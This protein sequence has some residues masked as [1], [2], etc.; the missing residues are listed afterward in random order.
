MRDFEPFSLVNGEIARQLSVLDRGLAYGDGLF[1]TMRL[2]NNCLP[3]LSLHLDRLFKSCHILSIGLDENLVRRDLEA[4]LLQAKTKGVSKGVVKLIVTR[5]AGGR[6]YAPA[7]KLEANRIWIVS[8]LPQIPASFSQDGVKVYLCQH[9]LPDHPRLAGIKHLNKLDYVLASQEWMSGDFQEGLLAD[10]RGRIVEACSRNVF[11]VSGDMLLTP[12]LRNAGVAGVL[13]RRIIEDYAPRMGLSVEET[14]IDL[15]TLADADELFLT[16][17]VTGA[18]PVRE[19]IGKEFSALH[20]SQMKI[21]MQVH[22]LF[23]EDLGERGI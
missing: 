17:S 11:V 18:W 2:E 22:K 15:Q 7:G 5:G 19:L 10:G 20:F 9:R 13:R 16:N 12:H 23:L 1:E 3:L 6:G 8:P 14:D 4:V 21:G